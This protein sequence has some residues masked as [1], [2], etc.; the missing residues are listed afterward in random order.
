MKE[1]TTTFHIHDSAYVDMHNLLVL[2]LLF[3]PYGT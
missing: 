3:I 1:G 2:V